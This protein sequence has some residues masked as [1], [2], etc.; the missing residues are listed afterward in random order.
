MGLLHPR[1][2]STHH[3]R[4]GVAGNLAAG[5][6][7]FHVLDT[8]DKR[9]VHIR[10]PMV[11][12]RMRDATSPRLRPEVRM[13]TPSRSTRGGPGALDHTSAGVSASAGSTAGRLSMKELTEKT[14]RP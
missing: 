8:T 10:L 4:K 12:G 2:R 13:R 14:A 5:H 9:P 1:A 7:A 6:R 3:R 11:A